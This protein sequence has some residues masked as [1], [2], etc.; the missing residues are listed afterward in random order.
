MLTGGDREQ[1]SCTRDVRGRFGIGTTKTLKR[2]LFFDGQRT[3][4]IVLGGGAW[5]ASSRDERETTPR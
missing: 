5:A 2:G 1:N 3:Q 4:R